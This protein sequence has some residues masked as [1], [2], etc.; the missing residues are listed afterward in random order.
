MPLFHY[1]AL[2]PSG[3]EIAG[4]L[5][6]DNERDAA[7]RLQAIGNYPIEITLPRQGA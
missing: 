5:T 4:E 7:Q 3:G 1:R 2:R 6:A